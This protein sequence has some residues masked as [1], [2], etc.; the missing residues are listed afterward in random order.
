VVRVAAW[1]HRASLAILPRR[2]TQ[3][4]GPELVADFAARAEEAY[5]RAGSL[6]VAG[7]LSRT[8]A[9]TLATGLT[10]RGTLRAE[11]AWPVQGRRFHEEK[12][13]DGMRSTLWRDAIV[14]VRMLA[15]RPIYAVVAVGTLALGIGATAAIFSVVNGVLVQPLPY[16]E[17]DRLVRVYH[18]NSRTGNDRGTFSLPDREDWAARTSSLEGLAVYSTGPSGPL[19]TGGDEAIEL[20]V[21]YVSAGFFDVLGRS[22]YLG[23]TLR[24]DEERGDSH[25][26]VLSH[27]FWERRFGGDESIVGRTIPIDDTGYLVAGVMPPDFGYP[28]P[29]VEAW[30]FLTVIPASSIPLHLRPVRVLDAVGRVAPGATLEQARQELSSV[31][32]ALVE[33][34]PEDNEDLDGVALVPLR[35]SMTAGVEATLLVLLGAVGMVLL[36]AC[37][38]VANLL[39]SRGLE[40]SRELGIR[41]ALGAGRGTLVRQLLT[42][43]ALLSVAGGSAGLAL[44][45]WGVRAVVSRSGDLLPRAG[46]VGI[47][48]TVLLFA[49]VVTVFTAL[50]FGLLPALKLSRHAGTDRL[51]SG[52]RGGGDRRA[53]SR[54]WAVLVGGQVGLATLVVISSGLLLRSVW[55]LQTVDIGFEPEGLVTLSLTLN[56]ARYPERPDYLG[57][58]ERLMDGLDR[59]PAVESV[60][61]IRYAPLRRDGES[62]N[63]TIPG[64]PDLVGADRPQATILQVSPGFFETAGVPILAGRDVSDADDAE[65]PFVVVVNDALRRRYW[66]GENPVDQTIGIGAASVRVV[67]LVGDVRQRSLAEDPIPTIYVAQAQNPRRGMAFMMRTSAD[68]ETLLPQVRAIVQSLDP[69]QPIQELATMTDVIFSAAAQP[70]FFS[71]LLTSF[72]LLAVV[73]SSFGIYGVV[74]HSVSRRVSE[75]GIRVAL[76]ASRFGVVRMIV[77]GGMLPVLAGAAVGLVASVAATRALRSIL[78]GVSA[79]DPLTFATVPLLLVA[80]AVWACWVPAARAVRIDPTE[81][82]RAE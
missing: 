35:E 54:T 32:S 17:S 74:N 38:N 77:M 73:L 50:A 3:D 15:R 28:S 20:R 52:T 63:F 43:S 75:I 64:R 19:L 45:Y 6:A 7:L 11:G 80:V 40:R 18:M 14:G 10:R 79:I 71:L 62:G 67:G 16:A 49:T 36:I 72:G 33:T 1:L 8:L 37:A 26:V 65:S 39:L 4:F 23:R 5:R 60:A 61:S 2:F 42:E 70:R 57:A 66:P 9:D 34:Y 56:D 13:G 78:F 68:P 82:L 47:D 30:L 59:M 53:T 22:A 24:D 21:A 51:S 12:G 81:A 55:E 48:G 29:D 44:A 31:A 58:Y 69:D 46:E 76:G 25:V 41:Q 27:G